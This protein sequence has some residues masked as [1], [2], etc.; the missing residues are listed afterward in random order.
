M[1]NQSPSPMLFQSISMMNGTQVWKTCYSL[2]KPLKLANLPLK[3]Y[4]PSKLIMTSSSTFNKKSKTSSMLNTKL[5][6]KSDL[7]LKGEL[8]LR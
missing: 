2:K 4:K 5:L 1:S 3:R 7:P 6:D 8:V